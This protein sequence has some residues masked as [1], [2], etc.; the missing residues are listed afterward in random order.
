L[1][2][3]L[4][5]LREGR[6]CRGAWLFL[7]SPNAA[8]VLAQFAF[9]ALI[10][11]HEHSPGSIET[12][13]HQMR[14]IRAAGDAT[15]LVRLAGLDDRAVK[16]VLDCGAEGLML[17]TV[18]GAAEAREFV[19]AC[20]YPPGGRRGAH[21]TVS[22]AASWGTRALEHYRDAGANLLLVAMIESVTGL[23][24]I[25]EIARVDGIGMIFVG[26]LDLSGSAGRMGE[27]D[28]PEVAALLR[29]AERAALATGVP[30]GTALIP[31]ELAG[32]CFARGIR[33]VTSGSDVGML[34]H[35][36]AASL[37]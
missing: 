18:H 10:I 4:A 31:G 27:W 12:A 8:E 25:P 24:A 26:P 23:E 22:R 33:F 17:P 16:L 7:G 15:I 34:R 2:R 6:Q 20:R 32:D 11:D 35:G 36:A 13:V 5:G 3:L 14:A 9:D 29:R 21:F 28:H 1:S 19:A 30:V 37:A